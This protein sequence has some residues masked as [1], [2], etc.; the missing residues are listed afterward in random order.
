MNNSYTA[1]NSHQFTVYAMMVA[2]FAILF[3]FHIYPLGLGDVYWHLNTGRWIWEHGAL[4]QTDPFTYTANTAG[5]AGPGLV[6]KDYWQHVTLQG[7]WLAQLLCYGVYAAFGLW[8]LVVFK[9]LLFLAIYGLVYRTLLLER[10]QP[11]L[12]LLV[13]LAFPVLFYR[14]DELRP[15]V[16]S[17]LGVVLV[18]MIMSMALMR[19]RTGNANPR[20]L[21]ALPL[22]M[23]VWANSH[24]GF[25]LG[26]IVIAA[27]LGG[28]LF[29][30]WR[31]I[32]KLERPALRHLFVWSGIALLAS[33]I[34]PLAGILF[35][36]AGVVRS[37]FGFGV[38][39][40]LPLFG[41][42][43]M[44]GQPFLFYG[45]LALVLVTAA[46]MLM[47]WKQAGAA[48]LFLFAGFAA[49]GFYAFRY[50]IFAVLMVTVIGIPHVAALLEPYWARLRLLMVILCLLAASGVG[51]LAFQRGGW[52]AGPEE[53]W[54][55]PTGA[56]DWIKTQHPPAPLFNAYEYGGY[57]GWRLT[58]DYKMFVDPRCLDIKVQNAYQ[59]ARGG[60]Y[61][62]VF[63][64]YGVNT[65]AFYILTPVVNSIPEITLY[66]LM[67]SHWDLVYVDRI[68]VVMVRHDRN[69]MPILDK[70]P[71]LDYLQRK[72][73]NTLAQTPGDTQAIV[74]YGRVLLYRG[75]VAGAVQR[76]RQ[77][78]EI[79]PQA[80]APRFYLNALS[81]RN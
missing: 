30:T 65:V 7:F 5:D 39:E 55:V 31:G 61:G 76:F 59:T 27:I 41:Y 32:G 52:K 60:F 3:W 28:E 40:F 54:Y 22:I 11:M 24:P 64:R 29:D 18:Y 80:Q 62:D 20:I 25:I 67:D 23:F 57:L 33:M 6:S 79:D 1:P 48:R 26:W 43:R 72:L 81:R 66:L 19:Q 36:Y 16:F 71:L 12:A 21:M 75:D 38:D 78:L 69:T 47:R 74:Q 73:E 17:F 77:A 50:M 44:Y 49:A 8:G 53:T 70:G 2:V 58:P 51:Y 15:Q 34:N 13:I 68:S 56:A 10:V 9:A 46:A 4:Q 14:F 42:A 37:Q 63:D 35:S 45:V